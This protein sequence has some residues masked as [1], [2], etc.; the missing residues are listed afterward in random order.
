MAVEARPQ[1]DRIDLPSRRLAAHRSLRIAGPAH[2]RRPGLRKVGHQCAA[3]I[4]DGQQPF[5]RIDGFSG[6]RSPRHGRGRR[7]EDR[8]EGL[9]H[10]VQRRK[11]RLGVV[12]V[13]PGL[14]D[15]QPD[16]PGFK[17][18]LG[19]RHPDLGAGAFDRRP[20]GGAAGHVLHHPDAGHGHL[21]R[22]ETTR[23]GAADRQVL[24]PEGQLRIRQGPGASAG[25][26]RR[27]NAQGGGLEARRGLAGQSQS[28]VEGQRLGVGRDGGG[29]QGE[30]PRQF[31][32]RHAPNSS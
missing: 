21:V 7:G 32:R 2:Q 31:Q 29:A 13:D 26:A 9:L 12:K 11:P 24:D 17:A 20:A 15:G 19:V 8:R 28:L 4:G 5:G 16:R 10:L 3:A 27:V 14:G 25:R 23:H 6:S 30:Q 22:P 1:H 18:C